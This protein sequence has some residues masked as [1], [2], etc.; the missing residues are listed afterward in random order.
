[1]SKKFLSWTTYLDL[2]LSVNLLYVSYL[3]AKCCVLLIDLDELIPFLEHF[4]IYILPM[5]FRRIIS[6]IY[7]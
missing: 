5:L 1:M 4:H 2:I 7:I 6:L 3:I